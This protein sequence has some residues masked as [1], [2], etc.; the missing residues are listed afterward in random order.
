[1]GWNTIADGSVDA[2]SPVNETLMTNMRDNMV[3]NHDRAVRSGT[4]A[5]GVRLAI[6]RGTYDFN[7]TIVTGTV[8]HA[9]TFATDA[10]DG[11]PNFSAAPL[12][13]FGM[14]E[15]IVT[16]GGTDCDWATDDT[17]VT[18]NIQDGTLSS[19]GMTV[20][21]TCRTDSSDTYCK[22]TLHWVAFGAV[23]SGE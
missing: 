2:D 18:A 10:T 5:T 1:M 11:D 15:R 14:E 3:Y 22:G 23:T 7:I 13:V 9:F 4:H 12:V 17:V 6:A 16:G 20:D 21:I 8:S 19:T